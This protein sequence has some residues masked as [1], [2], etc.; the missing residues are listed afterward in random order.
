MSTLRE[1]TDEQNRSE[2]P[3][4]ESATTQPTRTRKP[5]SPV[6]TNG[7]SSHWE[8]N[9]RLLIGT[10][11]VLPLILL[12]GF[13]SHL[14]Q[15]GRTANAFL[16][17]AAAA[18]SDKDHVEESKWLRRYALLRPDDA[19]VLIEMAIASDEAALASSGY[20]RRRLSEEAR[21]QLGYALSKLT[22]D[23][24]QP[25]Q[26][27]E[28]R[29]RL[30][31]R[32]VDSY[33]FD[34]AERQI[35]KLDAEVGDPEV[36]Q[37][38]ALSLAGQ[39][40]L[41]THQ[42]DLNVDSK[43]EV[44]YWQWLAAQP[45]GD[46]LQLAVDANPDHP[47]LAAT[48]VDTYL[49]SPEA[50]SWS[51]QPTSR[52]R[53][54][55][56]LTTVPEARQAIA[57]LPNPQLRIA[58]LIDSLSK[59]VDRGHSQLIAYRYYQYIDD[60][61]TASTII[62]IAADKAIQRLEANLSQNSPKP[63][64]ELH[65]A[66]EGQVNS[67]VEDADSWD[68]MIVL[69]AAD[70]WVREQKIN[71]A[72]ELLRR[73][74][75]LNLSELTAETVERGYLSY[76]QTWL[77]LQ[78]NEKAVEVW[79]SGIEKMKSAPLE[80]LRAV[81]ATLVYESDDLD[82]AMTALKRFSSGIDRAS[83]RLARSSDAD[84]KGTS[85]DMLAY[86]VE[87]AKW[88]LTVVRAKYAERKNAF[89]A[90]IELMQDALASKVRVAPDLRVRVAVDL[91]QLYGKRGLW[92][93]AG[94][95]YDRAVEFQ[96]NNQSLRTAAA[97]AWLRAGDRTKAL[98]HRREAETSESFQSLL[99][100][101]ESQLANQL[102]LLPSQRDLSDIRGLIQRAADLLN[103]LADANPQL[104]EEILSQSWRHKILVAYLPP[105]NVPLEQHVRSDALAKEIA[106][107]A[108]SDPTNEDLQA[109]AAVRLH[110]IDQTKLG[111][112]CLARLESITGTDQ[113]KLARIK[114]SVAAIHERYQDAAVILVK[115]SR[116]ESEYA[117]TLLEQAAEYAIR[118]GNVEFAYRAI[119]SVP[120]NNRNVPLLRKL[121]SLARALPEDASVLSRGGKTTTPIELS[122]KWEAALRKAEGE[123]GTYW[124]FAR[125]STIL[126]QLSNDS[127]SPTQNQ[128]RL[129]EVTNL[130]QQIISRRPAWGAGIALGG[131]IAA[132]RDD[133][134]N[135]INLLRRG[136]DA[137]DRRM[138]TRMLLVEQLNKQGRFEEAETELL[139]VGQSIGEEPDSMPQLAVELAQRQGD[140]GRSVSMARFFIKQRPEDSA[141]H[142]LLAQSL[143]L[144]AANE[145][146]T[147]QK[148]ALLDEAR[149]A[150]AKATELAGGLDLGLAAAKL[151]F[152]FTHGDRKSQDVIMKEIAKS[153]LPEARR[154]DLLAQAYLKLGETDQARK[155][156]IRSVEL[157]P[158]DPRAHM[159]LAS[160]YKLT[161]DQEKSIES[162][163][164]AH[165]LRPDDVTIK[166]QLALALA[167]RGGS[168][169]PWERLNQLLGGSGDSDGT[170][171]SRLLH[172]LLLA[173]SGDTTRQDQAH[174]MLQQLIDEA[175][176]SSLE[177]T[178]VLAALNR[179]RWQQDVER[180][181]SE[182]A[183]RWLDEAKR[184]FEVLVRRSDPQPIDLYRYADLLLISDQPHDVK[185]LLTE[186]ESIDA[187]AVAALD[188]AI[189]YNKTLEKPQPA[190]KIIMKWA[191]RTSSQGAIEP[192][193]LNSLAGYSL[194]Q[195]D[196]AEKA[197][198]LLQLAYKEN[199]SVITL[200]VQALLQAGL[201]ERAKSVC[202]KHYH[203]QG[204][205]RAATLLSEAILSDGN[206]SNPLPSEPETLLADALKKFP[207]N[208]S[209]LESFGTLRLQQQEYVEA[210]RLLSVATKIDP[211]RVRA[212]N[213]LAMAYS[214]IPGK[215]KLGIPPIDR[216]LEIA[217]RNPE[218]LDTKGVVLMKAGDLAG[219]KSAFGDAIE[220]NDDARFVFHMI[221]TLRAMGDTEEARQYW[222]SLD[223]DKLDIKGLA[224]EEKI[225]LEKMKKEFSGKPI[226]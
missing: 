110:A 92:D 115:R 68:S 16:R 127:G 79:R 15:S 29:R 74:T 144:A 213:N 57:A 201:F 196:Y 24:S 40:G 190:D 151:Q 194:L 182:D 172:G 170:A 45:V 49:K 153:S 46:V 52:S 161:G 69:E 96:P 4:N 23:G 62:T 156:L 219:A 176:P 87:V 59:Q 133:H 131:W 167:L 89:D 226:S 198:P 186:L 117:T 72:N 55:D 104:R 178:R 143:S 174:E 125:A 5:S 1:T 3:V 20:E 73:F 18:R 119:E 154:V 150:L 221:L 189:R 61:E 121:A 142:L 28:I 71:D 63:D 95:A 108:K 169:I 132:F 113:T 157:S 111:D 218:L 99:A 137:G 8:F 205:P 26:E 94:T 171:E 206:V 105:E 130:Y 134:E 25:Q 222:E 184:L 48:F 58:E 152:E 191:Q 141:A 11:I 220:Q 32:L 209:M 36:L 212:L 188:I 80:L 77:M 107:I 158:S 147:A 81:A 90:A 116:E 41:G 160:F 195:N 35:I 185:K 21:R 34:E 114:A 76:G 82:N 122:S 39:V 139:L 42:R 50:F 200:Y 13:A 215:A 208:T 138:K 93:Q 17:L 30:I 7:R 126:L 207:T 120:A 204:D 214:A 173:Q 60:Q 136:I 163:E 155:M 100:S 199:S 54:S 37:W 210:V 145:K 101:A 75:K 53:N 168:D 78:D 193:R 183:L 6:A 84:L 38:L 27:T 65:W 51:E 88:H 165:G 31:A 47:V 86:K 109:F 103:Q 159:N 217:P 216:A 187:A 146:K 9:W 223:I 197:V 181:A 140:F 102:T 97:V 192:D 22:S 203:E 66:D 118:G 56:S 43:E 85:R 33:R 128:A 177:A 148:D 98:R 224:P 19:K 67:K 175:G 211:N 225:E 112:E 83:V 91:A 166:N 179:R 123:N 14:Y 135:A 124:R 64:D 2:S 106:N 202:I 12:V 162:I 44:T 129:A 70:A 180:G 10:L 164:K 149:E